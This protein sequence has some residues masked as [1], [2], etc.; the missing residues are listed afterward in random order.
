MGILN[1]STSISAVK[2][3][4][5]VQNLLAAHGA[6]RVSVI[7]EA[8]KPLG[9]AFAITTEYGLRVFELPANAEGVFACLKVE[10]KAG[11]IRAN[12]ANEDQAVRTAWRIL[13]DWISA[14][15]AIIE[16][17]MV[18]LDEVMLPYMITP[19]GRTYIQSY[20]KSEDSALLA[21]EGAS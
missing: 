5:E 21:L 3:S 1:Y 2:T 11:K 20:R 10:S 7:F 13:K 9:I 12:F 16:A 17:G 4:S 18:T 14:Q 6:Q 19:S 15:L 8:G